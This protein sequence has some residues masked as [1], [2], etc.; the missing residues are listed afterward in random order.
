MEG[1]RGG[2]VQDRRERRRERR[3]DRR[4]WKGEGVYRKLGL[5]VSVR[6]L[7]VRREVNSTLV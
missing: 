4:R 7:S 1:G 5:T 3:R 6:Q 2:R